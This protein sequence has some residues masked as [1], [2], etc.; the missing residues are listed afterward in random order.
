[1]SATQTVKIPLQKSLSQQATKSHI[2]DGLHS[3]SIISLGQLCGD[4]CIAILDNNEIHI[5]KYS[6][7]ILKGRQNWLYVLWVIPITK[8]IQNR[9]HVINTRDIKN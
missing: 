8:P 4:H 1:M 5:L 7:L 9:P 3:A 2:F 6:T